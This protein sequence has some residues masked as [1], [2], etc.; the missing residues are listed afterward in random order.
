LAR[1]INKQ[2]DDLESALIESL[3]HNDGV[4]GLRDVPCK[5]GTPNVLQSVSD[6]MQARG[7]TMTS[8]PLD[9]HG[10]RTK[11][12]MC[13]VLVKNPKIDESKVKEYEQR[14][15]EDSPP[16]SRRSPTRDVRRGARGGQEQ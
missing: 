10:Y 3:V 13:R 5:A 7:L 4:I 11:D 12:Q 1:Q 8:V 6:K 9:N 15:T 16:R 14:L 2:I